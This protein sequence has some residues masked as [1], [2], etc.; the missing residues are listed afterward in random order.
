[1]EGASCKSRVSRPPSSFCAAS[2]NPQWIPSADPSS[3]NPAQFFPSTESSATETTG[4]NAQIEPPIHADKHRCGSERRL[5]PAGATRGLFCPPEA[6]PAKA[7]ANKHRCASERRLQPAGA[8]RGLFCPPEAQPRP[9]AV[10]SDCVKRQMR[11]FDSD[12][13]NNP[14]GAFRLVCRKVPAKC[15]ALLTATRNNADMKPPA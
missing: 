2:S 5:Q 1:M 3:G 7:I 4:M 6:Q 15:R 13:C 8:T 14:I 11:R 12:P 9:S 10:R